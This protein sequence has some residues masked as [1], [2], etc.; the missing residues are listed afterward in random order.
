[1][2]SWTRV[3]STTCLAVTSSPPGEEDNWRELLLPCFAPG[4]GA[5]TWKGKDVALKEKLGVNY[6]SQPPTWPGH[7]GSQSQG[8]SG[9]HLGKEG[10]CSCCSDM[11]QHLWPSCTA[12]RGCPGCPRPQGW[13][14]PGG[15]E[16][17]GYLGPLTGLCTKSVVQA[18]SSTALSC[19]AGSS[20]TWH[21]SEEA[22]S[23]GYN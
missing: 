4:I 12:L 15:G 21:C 3:A 2:Q 13:G 9:G 7:P 19:L 16:Y 18:P 20:P 8:T 5:S 23:W 14:C 10:R 6:N 22:T 17:A 1:M 11:G